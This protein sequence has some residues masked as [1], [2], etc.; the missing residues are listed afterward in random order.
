MAKCNHLT[1]LLFKGSYSSKFNDGLT[2]WLTNGLFFYTQ[3]LRNYIKTRRWNRL[4]RCSSISEWCPYIF[5][6]MLKLVCSLNY[7]ASV[8]SCGPRVI[9]SM[10]VL[11]YVP[12]IRRYL[13]KQASHGLWGSAGLKMS[14]HA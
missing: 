2:D 5:H 9:H 12:A 7:C 6:L 11:P 14:I 13:I 3:L 4:G 1:S 8:W 10:S